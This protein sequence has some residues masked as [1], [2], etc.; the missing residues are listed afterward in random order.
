[1]EPVTTDEAREHVGCGVVYTPHGGGPREDGTIT[2]VVAA[3]G[4]YVFVRYVGDVNAKATNA[5]D[6]TLLA[7]H[8]H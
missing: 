1:M 2:S 3:S 8:V 7:D 5:D 6:L 4:G